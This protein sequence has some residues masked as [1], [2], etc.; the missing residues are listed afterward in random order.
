[1]SDR[2]GFDS[3]SDVL[4]AERCKQQ[5]VGRL[6]PVTL[7]FSAGL[8]PGCLEEERNPF[9]PTATD[10]LDLSFQSSYT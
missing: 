6:R 2:R 5:E 8:V 7:S 4:Q 1:M 10:L 9:I 3:S